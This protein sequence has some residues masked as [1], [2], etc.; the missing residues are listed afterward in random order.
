MKE[1]TF[2]KEKKRDAFAEKIEK[3]DNFAGFYSWLDPK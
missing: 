3:K 2:D 1:K